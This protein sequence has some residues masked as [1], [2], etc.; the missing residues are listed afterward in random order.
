MRDS[1]PLHA[2]V[3]EE[4][5]SLRPNSPLVARTREELQARLSLIRVS[6]GFLRIGTGFHKA[7]DFDPLC[8]GFLGF[9]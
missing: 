3:P 9:E 8:Q 5:D 7:N 6:Y 1:P 2:S 4:A